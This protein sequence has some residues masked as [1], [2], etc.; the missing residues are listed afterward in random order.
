MNDELVSLLESILAELKEQRKEV[1]QKLT[2]I[3]G[4][5]KKFEVEANLSSK[6]VLTEIQSAVEML[7]EMRS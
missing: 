1:V 3:E 2:T 7:S 5:L 6:D 4:I